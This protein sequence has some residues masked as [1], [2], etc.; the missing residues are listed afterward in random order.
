MNPTSEE[1]RASVLEAA[2]ELGVESQS[3]AEWMNGIGERST[4]RT[5]A[6]G[7]ALTKQVFPFIASTGDSRNPYSFNSTQPR[8]YPS[9][10][11]SSSD[12]HS[13]STD[14]TYSRTSS[15]FSHDYSSSSSHSYQSASRVPFPR[16]RKPSDTAPSAWRSVEQMRHRKDS[17]T[18]PF[19]SYR[20]PGDDGLTPIPATR[21]RAFPHSRAETSTKK[22]EKKKL[23]KK[24]PSSAG[25]GYE[26]DGGALLGK[27]WGRKST[28]NSRPSSPQFTL[29]HSSGELTRPRA[30]SESHKA[31]RLQPSVPFIPPIQANSRSLAVIGEPGRPSLAS[32]SSRPS[33]ASSTEGPL[34]APVKKSKGFR[35]GFKRSQSH[36]NLHQV[37]KANGSSTSLNYAPPRINDPPPLPSLRISEMLNL[38]ITDNS[39]SNQ[40]TPTQGVPHAGPPVSL[41]RDLSLGGV[42]QSNSSRG[43]SPDVGRVIPPS[44]KL[45][46]EHMKAGA[47]N[48][49]GIGARGLGGGVF[50]GNSG[51]LIVGR[52]SEES[53]KRGPS[54]DSQRTARPRA[55]ENSAHS[56]TSVDRD[57]SIRSEATIRNNRKEDSA[58]GQQSQE[59]VR[60]IE[61]KDP[62]PQKS[63]RRSMSL[64]A[65]DSMM[66]LPIPSRN[67]ARSRSAHGIPAERPLSE[68][69]VY[70][71]D[72]LGDGLDNILLAPPNLRDP[73]RQIPPPSPPPTGPL[74][75]QPDPGLPTTPTRPPRGDGVMNLAAHS[76]SMYNYLTPPRSPAFS[77]VTDESNRKHSVPYLSPI[78]GQ[79]IIPNPS[80]VNEGGNSLLSHVPL[81]PES[82]T[83]PR[84]LSAPS[85]SSKQSKYRDLALA[86]AIDTADPIVPPRPESSYTTATGIDIPDYL[87]PDEE[88]DESAND[89]TDSILS[90]QLE[91]RFSAGA[92]FGGISLEDLTRASLYAP[93][94]R[95]QPK[96]LGEVQLNNPMSIFKPPLTI[97]DAQPADTRTNSD[98]LVRGAHQRKNTEP[99]FLNFDE[100][101]VSPS[102]PPPPPIVHNSRIPV[103]SMVMP[104][105]I[106]GRP[107]P[108]RPPRIVEGAFSP[109]PASRRN[110]T[111]ESSK[112]PPRSVSISKWL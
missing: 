62:V 96:A 43:V 36:P 78:G 77:P 75:S 74:P 67:P 73:A 86:L 89:D 25:D 95:G 60:K 13:S 27:I 26:S 65:S 54:F 107:R 17:D 69:S 21:E 16:A 34:S 12:Y 11:G 90:V 45:R 35:W 24:K 31:P 110:I 101:P 68:G 72:M 6:D 29:G 18:P 108:P 42:E 87:Q 10:Q 3:F 98:Y 76:P 52:I 102:S 1:V 46:E 55:P 84:V 5:N 20:P 61:A 70:E 51:P 40:V 49:A 66:P 4:G 44:S 71:E 37:A 105:A 32:S 82:L 47:A 39:I 7:A 41:P 63:V 30:I 79:R 56:P 23:K 80:S 38:T 91:N 99:S 22:T 59:S 58:L 92:G 85:S 19:A 111:E 94:F 83:E 93:I 50:F 8:H 48:R 88:Y 14:Y 103:A 53:S 100:E 9:R 57:G 97:P 33:T 28:S 104:L 2:L 106:P 112:R 109:N 81:T 64:T 15:S